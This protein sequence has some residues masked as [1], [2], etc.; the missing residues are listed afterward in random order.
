[1][2]KKT[3]VLCVAV[4]LVLMGL[5]NVASA[6]QNVANTS[7]KGS[8]LIWPAI[9]T[10]NGW[11]TIIMIGNDN[12]AGTTI[13][14]LWM[15][16]WQ[17]VW[18]FEFPITANQPVW[19]KASDGNGGPSSNGINSFGYDNIGELKCFAI[20]FPAADGAAEQQV[21][22][23][24]LYGSA[25]AFRAESGLAF[26]YPAWSFTA[27]GNVATGAAVGTPG[28]MLL[29]GGGAG[30]Y[31]ACPAYLIYNFFADNYVE[32]GISPF[33]SSIALSPCKQDLTQDRSPTCTKAKFDIWNENERKLTG[34]YHCVKC[35]FEGDLDTFGSTS[36]LAT[37]ATSGSLY[38]G[39]YGHPFANG[40]GTAP[41][42]LA[43]F[44]GTNFDYKTA[45]HTASGRFRVTG[46]S[47][48]TV[49]AGV[50]TTIDPLTGNLVDLC[51]ASKQVAVP[52]VGLRITNVFFG[53]RA[54]IDSALGQDGRGA[55]LA[56]TGST[57]GAWVVPAGNP[58]PTI[59]WDAADG[60]QQAPGK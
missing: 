43:G 52:F 42:K 31:D 19:F 32:P 50:Y 2:F 13:K 33:S 47:G 24:H 7:Q 21:A 8:L 36:M 6:A 17:N 44:G 38:Y 49:C 10:V 45:L 26:E 20:S 3:L 23:N 22:W 1:M 37:E 40:K 27:R 55:L 9:V 4:A 41:P 54:G 57:A 5:C 16:W 12:T 34:T 25:I 53:E 14:C 29:T 28:Q 30:T 48:G 18:N 39:D 15:D 51:P 58:T 35:W 46:I 59:L 56:N 11:D 60:P